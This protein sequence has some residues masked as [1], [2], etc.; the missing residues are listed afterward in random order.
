VPLYGR[1]THTLT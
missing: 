1:A